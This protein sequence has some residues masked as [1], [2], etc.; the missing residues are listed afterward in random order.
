LKAGSPSEQLV[1]AEN[2]L[3]VR[4]LLIGW[5]LSNVTRLSVDGEPATTESIIEK[6]PEDFAN[7]VVTAIRAELGLSEP[8]IKNS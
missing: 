5:G 6:A 1:A 2:E 4:K 3:A 8:E 7:E